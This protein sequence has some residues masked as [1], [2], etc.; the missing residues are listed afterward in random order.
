MTKIFIEEENTVPKARK[1]LLDFYDELPIMEEFWG[2]TIDE[3]KE[4]Q[5]KTK[6][7][8]K[9]EP[10]KRPASTASANFTPVGAT[11]APKRLTPSRRSRSVTEAS[12]DS[13]DDGDIFQD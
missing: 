10:K 12:K 11:P 2:V 9:K 13:D 6:G 5:G 1:K 4:L 3:F 7:D 8:K